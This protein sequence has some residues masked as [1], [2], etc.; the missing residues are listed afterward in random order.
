[1]IR[2]LFAAGLAFGLAACGGGD[3]L[4]LQDVQLGEVPNITDLR[5]G[6]RGADPDP[7]YVA[8]PLSQRQGGSPAP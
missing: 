2:V 4:V 1:M 6:F 7:R 3:G 8:N 5:D